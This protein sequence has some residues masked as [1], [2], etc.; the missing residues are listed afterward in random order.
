MAVCGD[1]DGDSDGDNDGDSGGDSG[2][3]SDG[4]H[5]RRLPSWG[6]ISASDARVEVCL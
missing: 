4:D 3:D 5:L 6:L 2:G 1:S